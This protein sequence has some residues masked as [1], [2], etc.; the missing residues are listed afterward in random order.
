M[1]TCKRWKEIFEAY[2]P[3]KTKRIE[4]YHVQQFLPE[5]TSFCALFLLRVVTGCKKPINMTLCTCCEKVVSFCKEKRKGE[6][7]QF[8][9]FSF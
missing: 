2:D 8:K 1:L 6:R 4:L 9:D 7:I 5:M 3:N